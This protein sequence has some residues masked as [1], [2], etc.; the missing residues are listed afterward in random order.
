MDTP[1]SARRATTGPRP[2]QP[3][4][5]QGYRE[6]LSAH[7][8]C[9]NVATS[10]AYVFVLSLFGPAGSFDTFTLPERL[11]FGALYFCVCWP[12][13][14]AQL[15]VALYLCRFRKPRVIVLVL[16]VTTIYTSFP[17]STVVFAVES[18]AHPFYSVKIG[19]LHMFVLTAASSVAWSTLVLVLG[20][21]T[22]QTRYR[23]QSSGCRPRPTEGCLRGE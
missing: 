10:A 23:H 17:A 11:A 14:Y 22:G 20:V 19:L 21:A 4:M 12:M 16:A 3:S 7:M 1:M 5:Q 15:V 8:I 6:A 18:L 2:V 9:V 13:L